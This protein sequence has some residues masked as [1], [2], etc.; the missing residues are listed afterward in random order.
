MATPLIGRLEG[1][2]FNIPILGV[3]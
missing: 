1:F 3:I 2:A